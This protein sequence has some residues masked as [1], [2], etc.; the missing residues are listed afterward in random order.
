MGEIFRRCLNASQFCL[1]FGSLR[2][3]K[4]VYGAGYALEYLDG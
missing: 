4:V 1:R 2:S 3:D